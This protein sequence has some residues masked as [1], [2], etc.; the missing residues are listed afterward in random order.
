MLLVAMVAQG[1]ITIGRMSVIR[2]D[3]QR[4]ADAGALAALQV[5]GERGLPFDAPAQAA[6]EAIAA[7]NSPNGV[8][9]TWRV[10]ETPTSIDITTSAAIDV[11]TPLLVFA[12]GSSEVR[13]RGVARLPQTRFDEAERRLPKLT[14]V[15]DYS[16]SMTLP[17][18]GGNQ[19]AIDV[20]EDSVEGL[21]AA[22][23]DVDYGGVFYSNNVFRTVGIGAGAPNQ[24]VT[25]MNT[26]DA[27]GGTNTA[28]GLNAARNLLSAAPDTGRYVLLVSDGEPNDFA[29]ARSAASQVWDAGMTIFTLEVRRSGSGNALAQFMTDVAG[30][31]SSRRDPGFHYVATSASDLVNEFKRIVASIV[32]K[33]GP[34]TPAPA[35][36]ADLRVYL[37]EGGVERALASSTDLAADRDLERFRYEPGDA[38]VRLTATACEPVTAGVA[39]IVVRHER[40]GLTE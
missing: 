38:S 18:T 33:V 31:P 25:A 32:C 28:A 26:Y 11:D 39:S 20:L 7:R 37:R 13:A 15:L 12:T 16:G 3:A 21:L 17:F 6:A 24:I 35:D 5:I 23:L 2:A 14:L 34:L 30:T 22:G 27:G 8:R 19:R 4:A 29:A 1:S 10:T 40:P 9:L 36:A